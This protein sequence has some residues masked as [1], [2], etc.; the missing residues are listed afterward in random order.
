MTKHTYFN[1]IFLHWSC[2]VERHLC[3]SGSQVIKHYSTLTTIS[4]ITSSPPLSQSDHQAIPTTH[5]NHNSGH[6]H[7][8]HSKTFFLDLTLFTSRSIPRYKSNSHILTIKL[9]LQ[10]RTPPS[11]RLHTATTS[12]LL[13]SLCY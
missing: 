13:T 10:W 3:H 12:Y 2:V 7:L 4:T 8:I 9:L 6:A 5:F 11:I 1:D